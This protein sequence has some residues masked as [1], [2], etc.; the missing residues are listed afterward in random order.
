[1]KLVIQIPCYNEGLT[2]P[3]VI[4]DLPR[5]VSGVDKV[6]F[7]IV[8]DGSTDGTAQIARSLGVDHVVRH[9]RNLGLARAFRTGLDACLA[10]GADIIVNTDGDNQYDGADVAALVAPILAGEADL[11]VGDRQTD[12]IEH[13]SP[14]KRLLQKV[15][16]LVVRLVSGVE[17]PDAVSGFRAMSRQAAMRI[18]IVSSF[19]YTIEMLIQSRAK[20]FAVVA[21]PVRTNPK[22]RE[23]RLFRSPWRFI[24][25]SV[26]TMLRMYAMYK[27]LRA[28]L[29]V[30]FALTFLG[31]LPIARF[32]WLFFF[33]VA[34]GHIQSLVLGGVLVVIGLL[35]VLVGVVADLVGFNRQLIEMTLEKVRHLELQLAAR[36]GAD[37]D[38]SEPAGSAVSPAK[39]SRPRSVTGRG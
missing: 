2:L 19:S 39:T 1:M 5:A 12:G 17:I 26:T 33:D 23:S 22:T 29:Y 30:G 20:G 31:C 6:E 27:P 9:S 13:F 7:L 25:R 10:A 24:E 32:L 8:D 37:G 36:D 34:G 3:A 21:V 16:S 35:T 18:N 38:R 14:F 11:V 15:G 28:F 4:R